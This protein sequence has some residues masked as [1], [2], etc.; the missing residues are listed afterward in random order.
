MI[1]FI[2]FFVLFFGAIT[3]GAWRTI[4][5]SNAPY[6]E[7]YITRV[8]VPATWVNNDLDGQDEPRCDGVADF[9]LGP[10][11]SGLTITEIYEDWSYPNKENF[12]VT[13]KCSNGQKKS[14]T[15]RREDITG[16]IEI[17]R[18]KRLVT[19]K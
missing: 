1:G 5:S 15:Y 2:I 6:W 8:R 3:F 4:Q 10:G 18:N 11:P 7:Q 16:R 12:T 13:Q 9:I 19:P 14:F 17:S